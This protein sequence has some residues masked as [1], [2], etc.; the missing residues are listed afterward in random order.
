VTAEPPLHVKVPLSDHASANLTEILAAETAKGLPETG[1]GQWCLRAVMDQIRQKGPNPG[2]VSL[3][4]VVNRLE[5]A[6][7]VELPQT[8]LRVNIEDERSFPLESFETG[9]LEMLIG[10]GSRS[11][12]ERT[13]AFIEAGNRLSHFPLPWD[14]AREWVRLTILEAIAKA[15][16]T[17]DSDR[18][19]REEKELY[20]PPTPKAVDAVEALSG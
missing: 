15:H 20:P 12:I 18:A 2:D 16:T 7:Y 3:A 1:R 4:E 9:D 19:Q 11:L 6:G 13:V 5:T 14:S 17:V 10:P 8:R